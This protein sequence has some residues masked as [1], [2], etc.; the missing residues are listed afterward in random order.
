[1]LKDISFSSPRGELAM[2]P[3]T[4]NLAL[5]MYLAKNVWKDGK[6]VQEIIGTAVKG[7]KIPDAPP[8]KKINKR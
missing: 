4:H 8:E 6:I 1:M 2:D 7:L 5:D 3:K